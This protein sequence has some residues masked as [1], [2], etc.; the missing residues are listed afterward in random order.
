MRNQ[1]PIRL[2]PGEKT[3]FSFEG[4]LHLKYEGGLKEMRQSRV[5]RGIVVELK[6][7]IVSVSL[8][9]NMETRDGHD[10]IVDP[11]ADLSCDGI[12]YNKVSAIACGREGIFLTYESALDLEA[13]RE[14]VEAARA[15]R[16]QARARLE[17]LRQQ[18]A[19]LAE[20]QERLTRETGNGERAIADLQTSIQNANA[21]RDELNRQRAELEE[22]LQT[23][24][25]Q[26]ASQASE[27]T[28]LQAEIDQL[29]RRAL[30]ARSAFEEAQREQSE[31]SAQLE[32]YSPENLAV[33]RRRNEELGRQI[34]EAR[35]AHDDLDGQYAP[36][37]SQLDAQTQANDALRAEIEAQPEELRHLQQT[38][39][40]LSG[41]LSQIQ[42]ALVECS[43]EK[44][45]ELRARIEEL[46]P[47]AERL[48]EAYENLRANEGELSASAAQL[49]TDNAQ[50][51]ERVLTLMET[52][53]GRL[54]EPFRQA[55]QRRDRF[56]AGLERLKDDYEAC[57]QWLNAAEPPL[58]SM[59]QAAGTDNDEYEDLRTTL[60]VNRCAQVREDIEAARECLERLDGVLRSGMESVQ[61]DNARKERR[62]KYGEGN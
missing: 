28:V 20:E 31:L 5:A 50:A 17:E 49:E 61:R 10:Y 9:P 40:E 23:L 14:R 6:D 47:K 18:H 3:E 15:A 56:K 59:I 38:H 22:Q 1:E 60:D 34:V 39:E 26:N 27:N 44:Q 57:S 51:V 11:P 46:G 52:A 37:K 12:R 8:A 19:Q 25:A 13:W 7:R 62:A 33:L 48:R 43:E 30:A 36:L 2:I 24:N 45:N 35:E 58:A 42:N 54:E 41:R 29:R 32:A 21:R 53:C 55:V 4:P 16:E